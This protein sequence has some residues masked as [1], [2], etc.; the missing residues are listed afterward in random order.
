LILEYESVTL[1]T[2]SK[3]ICEIIL[4][5]LESPDKTWDFLRHNPSSRLSIGIVLLSAWAITMGQL[6]VHQGFLGWKGI[7]S[8]FLI[9]AGFL[10]LLWLM[11]S[12]VIH[13]FAGFLGGKTDFQ[14]LRSSLGFGLTP[15]LLT[16]VLA[17]LCQFL[18]RETP[19]EMRTIRFFYSIAFY[20]LFI[21][22]ASLCI[23]A[24]RNLYGFSTRKSLFVL[25]LPVIAI[26]IVLFLVISIFIFFV[27]LMAIFSALKLVFLF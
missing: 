12:T 4:E 1:Q 5:V 20:F 27:L 18:I 23:G 11:G 10:T 15:F 14:L 3:S 16:T 8:F 26:S 7:S 24:I 6:A 2:P 9:N 13:T 21:W 19:L 17:L 22:S 25:I